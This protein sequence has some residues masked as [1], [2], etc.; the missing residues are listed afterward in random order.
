MVR[1]AAHPLVSPAPV[2]PQVK[3][4]KRSDLPVL[5]FADKILPTHWNIK[6]ILVSYVNSL[7]FEFHLVSVENIVHY[8]LCVI[9]L[10]VLIFQ[11][12]NTYK[13]CVHVYVCIHVYISLFLYYTVTIYLNIYLCML[14]RGPY[15]TTVRLSSYAKHRDRS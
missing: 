12:Q 9:I 3:H 13:M 5:T 14:S 2:K 11:V 7:Y 4:K 6:N 15:P 10:M 8:F 1:R